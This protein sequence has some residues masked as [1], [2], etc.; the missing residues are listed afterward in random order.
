MDLQTKTD[1]LAACDIFCLPSS[2][3][4]FGAVFLEAW[5]FGKPVI[6]LDIPQIRYLVKD[7]VNG[8]LVKPVP[9]LI[10]QKI[11][12]L[13]DNPDVARNMGISGSELVKNNFT[14]SAL[15]EKTISAYEQILAGKYENEHGIQ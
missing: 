15:S 5:A 9:E 12:G 13:L 8:C 3:E 14:W 10:A 1:A 7:G 2:Q 4:S 11:T 6:A